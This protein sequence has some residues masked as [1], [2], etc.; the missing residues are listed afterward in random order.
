M[1]GRH[2]AGPVENIGVWKCPACGAP[3]EGKLQ[4]GCTSCG[5]GGQTARKAEDRSAHLNGFQEALNDGTP[6]ID[7]LRAAFS[8]FMRREYPNAALEER[9]MTLVWDAFKAGAAYM[10]TA[11]AVAEPPALPLLGTVESRTIIAALGF[12]AEQ[13][14]SLAPEEVKTGE[15]LGKEDT[16]NLIKRL[17]AS[18]G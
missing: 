18:N 12:F 15:W 14:L 9:F 13:I 16:L 17:E 5:S 1:A 2:Y 4:D 3:N 8:E 11:A 6:P 10:K 7:P